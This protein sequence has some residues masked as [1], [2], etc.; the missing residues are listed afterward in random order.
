LRPPI[1][2]TQLSLAPAKTPRTQLSLA[3]AKTPPARAFF[4]REFREREKEK[5][6]FS[7]GKMRLKCTPKKILVAFV[8]PMLYLVTVGNIQ[9]PT[10]TKR[11]ALKGKRP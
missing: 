5:D 4:S 6:D 11:N 9:Q 8:K 1:P 2:R 7:L 10:T 3:P